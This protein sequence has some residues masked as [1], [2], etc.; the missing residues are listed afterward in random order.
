MTHR[1]NLLPARHVERM[2]TRRAAGFAAGGLVVLMVLLGLASLVQSAQLRQAER[3]R[4]IEQA[5]NVELQTRRKALAPFRQLSDGIVGR[6]RLLTAAMETQVSWT[7]VLTSLS[8]TFP[9]DASLTSLTAESLVPSFGAVPPVKSA[10][11]ARVIGSTTL[12]GY[13]V[14]KFTPGV[15]RMLQL[16]EDVNGLSEPRL[17]EGTAEKIGDRPVTTFD[18]STFVD[19]AAL[20]GRYAGGLPPEDDVKVPRTGGGAPAP[21]APSGGGPRASK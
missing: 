18:G 5:R 10:D 6:E 21:P 4:D 9:S 16:L 8:A 14:Q 19:G 1:F 17:Q 2:A 13:S 12:K 15:E 3:E 7:D 20:S 11:K